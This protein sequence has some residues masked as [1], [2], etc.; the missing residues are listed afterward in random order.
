MRHAAPAADVDADAQNE[1]AAAV[2]GAQEDTDVAPVVFTNVPTG[3]GSGADAD[4]Q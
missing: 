4:K 1:P 3:H 2:H